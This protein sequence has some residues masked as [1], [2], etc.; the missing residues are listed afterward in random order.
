[1]F[2]SEKN[3]SHVEI[4]KNFFNYGE[5]DIIISEISGKPAHSIHHIIY[6]SN[7]G[8]DIIENLIALTEEEPKRAH[9]LIKP[10][11]KAEYLFKIH[12]IFIK[13]YKKNEHIKNFL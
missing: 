1:M 5:Q 10:Y 9:F 4:Y 7:G 3:A 12:N 11:I 2:N 6:L 13:I 8:K